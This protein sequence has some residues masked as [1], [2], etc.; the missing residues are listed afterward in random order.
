LVCILTLP[1]SPTISPPCPHPRPRSNHILMPFISTT[2][3]LASVSFFSPQHGYKPTPGLTLADLQSNNLFLDSIYIYN[4][5]RKP[6]ATPQ[7][8]S[9]R[10]SERAFLTYPNFPLVFNIDPSP[11]DKDRKALSRPETLQVRADTS[12]KDF[13][14]TLGEPDRKGGG[15]GPSSGS[16]GIWCEWS[17]D[18]IMVEF[19][20]DEA[21]GPQAWERGKDAIWKIITLF[22]P[23]K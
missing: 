18:G 17:K 8:T 23:A 12:G 9:S 3:P 5:P 19:G 15:A 14:Q 4:D 20:G 1:R 2:S 21:I 22:S 6:R 7:R 13:V 11:E 16:I 10:T